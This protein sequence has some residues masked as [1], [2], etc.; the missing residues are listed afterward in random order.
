MR[1][2]IICTIGPSTDSPEKVR[3]LIDAGMNVA[4]LNF[5]HD[6]RE[7][8]GKRI[9]LIRSLG[10]KLGKKIEILCDLQGPKIRIADFKGAPLEIK[11]GQQWVFET[12]KN[13]TIRDSIIPIDDPYL[14]ADVSPNDIIL[15]D[16]GLLEFIVEKVKERRIYCRAIRDGLLLPRKGVNLPLTKT[17]TSSLTRKD[18]GDLKYALSKK[19]EM[20]AISFVQRAEDILKVKKIVN[21]PK[22]RLISKIE[23]ATALKNIHEIIDV[24]DG[25]LVARGDLGVEVPIEKLPILQKQIIKSCNYTNKPVITATH[26][27]SSMVNAPFPT[28]AEVTDIFNAVYD[29]SD[30]VMLSNETTVG[31]Y[32]IESLKMMVKIVKA[33][34][35]YLYN[36]PNLL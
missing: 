34:E 2:K 18:L 6:A 35:E 7:V 22:I 17:T 1:T 36:R 3:A 19:P 8:H 24:S 9:D 26:M 31:N 14:H 20:I 10:Q 16:D 32:P 13:K 25:V 12:S 29:G 4:R 23:R 27:L 33:T 28:R 15:I 30:A 21:N 5:S 11:E